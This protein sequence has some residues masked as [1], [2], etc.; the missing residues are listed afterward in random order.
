MHRSACRCG[1]NPTRVIEIIRAAAL[2]YLVR[3]TVSA[4]DAIELVKLSLRQRSKASL[5]RFREN[6]VF[7]AFGIILHQKGLGCRDDRHKGRRRLLPHRELLRRLMRGS[8]AQLLR[9]S[10]L[11]KVRAVI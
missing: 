7:P 9:Y 5:C 1:A 10:V 11:G 4:A 6:E 2:L 3:Q 8:T